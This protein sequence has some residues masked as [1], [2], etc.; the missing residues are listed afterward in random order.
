MPYVLRPPARR[1]RAIAAGRATKRGRAAAPRGVGHSCARHAGMAA[2]S[3]AAGSSMATGCWTSSKSIRTAAS[4]MLG[5]GETGAEDV[6][7]TDASERLREDFW[8]TIGPVLVVG[9]D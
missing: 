7:S 4:G 3:T 1:V 2:T 6:L 9:L 5:Q 8:F